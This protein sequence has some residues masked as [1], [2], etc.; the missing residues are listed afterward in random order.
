MI[1]KEDINKLTDMLAETMKAVQNAVTLSNDAVK[2]IRNLQNN[3]S[4]LSHEKEELLAEVA[5]LQKEKAQLQQ[6]RENLDI[7]RKEIIHE[8]EEEVFKKIQDLKHV[9]NDK[10]TPKAA[11]KKPSETPTAIVDQF[12]AQTAII[13][14]ISKPEPAIAMQQPVRDIAKAI[15][16]NDRFLFIREL[17]DGDDAHFT[18]TINKLNSMTS[19]EEAKKYIQSAVQHWDETS[20]PAQFFLSILQRRYIQKK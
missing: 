14:T 3:L 16:I 2:V 19:L 10:I 9:V 12:K 8:L 4:G 15:A 5:E 17:F 13:D 6:A 20:E 18:Q 1:T 7:K 11:A